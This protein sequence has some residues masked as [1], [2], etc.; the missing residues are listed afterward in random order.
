MKMIELSDSEVQIHRFFCHCGAPEHVLEI[1]ITCGVIEID[2]YHG[3]KCD[4]SFWDRL[5]MAI[6]L[7]L[8]RDA[9][10][11]SEFIIQREDE[12]EI[13]KLISNGKD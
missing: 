10:S 3:G 8:K 2:Y 9:P 11:W 1:T 12:K 13:A 7:L 6:G 4:R 5:K